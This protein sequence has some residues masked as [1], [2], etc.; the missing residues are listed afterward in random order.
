MQQMK[1]Q[2]HLL[3]ERVLSIEYMTMQINNSRT[4][5]EGETILGTK[6]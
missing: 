3:S 6:K 2:K 1:R 4:K 5:Y